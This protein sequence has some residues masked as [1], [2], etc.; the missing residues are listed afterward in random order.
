MCTGFLDIFDYILVVS[1]KWNPAKFWNDFNF[2]KKNVR[3]NYWPYHDCQIVP[4]WSVTD[5]QMLFSEN[6]AQLMSR[7]VVTLLAAVS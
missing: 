4:D 6:D 5:R 1:I 3:D 7:I 2:E